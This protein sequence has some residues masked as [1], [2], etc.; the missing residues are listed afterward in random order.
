MIGKR[1]KITRKTLCFA[2]VFAFVFS[3]CA[4]KPVKSYA[5]TFEV[6]IAADSSL[7]NGI[8]TNVW[9]NDGNVKS[10]DGSAVWD[11]D[12]SESGR[13]VAMTKVKDVAAD[14]I[15]KSLASGYTFS[16]GEAES[17]AKFV[18]A[19]GLPRL[20]SAV[21]G[22]G[23]SAVYFVKTENGYAA[24][25]SKFENGK[26]I[27]V[28]SSK[29]IA[30]MTA[31]K[32]VTLTINVTDGAFAVYARTENGTLTTICTA[33]TKGSDVN[34][35]GYLCIARSG[36][37]NAKLSGINIKAY[38][39]LN[40]TTPAHDI[41]Y[42]TFSGGHYNG[43][44]WF[45]HA[46]RAENGGI[47]VE[48]DALVMRNLERGGYFG[49]KFQYSNF[50]LRFDILHV[51]RTTE[52]DENNNLLYR[53]ESNGILAVSL[54][55]SSYNDRGFVISTECAFAF[56]PDGT[57]QRLVSG[58]V[59]EAISLEASGMGN[60]WD[61]EYEGRIVNV[62]ITSTDG[63]CVVYCRLDG[64]G[65]YIPVMKYASESTPYGYVK[66]MAKEVSNVIIDNVEIENTDAN[67]V[68]TIENDKLNGLDGAVDYDYS[69]SWSDGDLL[70][71]AKRNG[72]RR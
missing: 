3:L 43:S 13:I 62:K 63:V 39:Y 11:D 28:V 52:T 16:L 25:V 5:G 33:K 67:A 56:S 9:I 44:V 2:I 54:G 69:D 22:D 49:T 47:F 6:L 14:G 40:A 53:K 17:G 55:Q 29:T 70:P 1:N 37:I 42:E 38:E 8:A 51:Q 18:F 68:L 20:S 24:G 64:I 7:K 72:G 19:F 66:I 15:G 26:E 32:N 45:S 65:Q 34:A 71:W 23:T 57:V 48:N 31:G 4:I 60:F 10:E 41:A 58:N 59:A 36:K 21:F 50:D 30:G 12:V 27:K 35:A 61:T 46:G